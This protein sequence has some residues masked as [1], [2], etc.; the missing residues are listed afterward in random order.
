VK[1]IIKFW[2]IIDLLKSI[3]QRPRKD[4]PVIK[5]YSEFSG[6]S[7]EEIL[8][9]I[10]NYK[11]LTSEEWRKLEAG[12]YEDKAK[13]F[14]KTSENYIYDLLSV[15]YSKQA[16][17]T[18]L[19]HFDPKIIKMIKDH[20][21]SEF[22][23][24]GGGTGVFCEIVQG[25]GKNVTYLD[26]PGKVY[27]FADWRFKKYG[28]PVTMICSDP[29][30]L[31]LEKKYDVVFSDA[32]IE[33]VIDPPQ[34]IEELCEHINDGGLFILL[35]D[36]EGY[37]DHH[38]MHRNVDIVSLHKIIQ[39]KGLMNISGKNTFCSIWKKRNN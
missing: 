10:K 33:H 35:V 20:P 2:K 39:K 18:K 26:I 14:Y 28:I 29:G 15:N 27:D 34:I 22:L 19:D 9:Y 23:E 1:D 36:I 24:F 37:S 38:P 3:R 6:L 13:D 32:V 30:K 17:T 8:G 31:R 7:I 21:G 12:T 11:K 16:V 4:S 5:D 25:F